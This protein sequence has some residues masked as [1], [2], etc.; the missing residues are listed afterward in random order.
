V[1]MERLHQAFNGLT[2]VVLHDNGVKWFHERPSFPCDSGDDAEGSFGRTS[3]GNDR[4][5]GA[6]FLVEVEAEVFSEGV[7]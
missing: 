6:C 3:P 4:F 7:P 1:G 2:I 5:Q